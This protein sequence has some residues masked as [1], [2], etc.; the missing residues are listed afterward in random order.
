[1][2]MARVAK[3]FGVPP[4][5]IGRMVVTPPNEMVWLTPQDL[6]SM[7]TSMVGQ[8]AQIADD[9]SKPVIP[10]QTGPG[11]PLDIQSSDTRAKAL[12][13]WDE[14]VD[15][16]W[17]LSA[18]Q[19]NGRAKTA[20]GCQPAIKLCFTAVIYNDSDGAESSLKIARDMNDKIVKREICS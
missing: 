10:N 2:S 16:A 13:T 8:P 17:A 11:A 9:R 19:N 20:K 7:G 18:R 1:M 14:I 3:D 6:Q 15:K 12:P 5:I 4:A